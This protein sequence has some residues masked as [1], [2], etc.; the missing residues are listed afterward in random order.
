M[1]SALTCRQLPSVP[2]F[3]MRESLSNQHYMLYLRGTGIVDITIISRTIII[4][5][6]TITRAISIRYIRYSIRY[7]GNGILLPMSLRRLVQAQPLPVRG[8]YGNQV[9]TNT[10][11][12]DPLHD[13]S[14]CDTVSM[15]YMSLLIYPAPRMSTCT[16]LVN[17]L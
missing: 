9:C 11:A 7:P 17:D 4:I 12:F 13:M 6:T 1:S 10:L 5:I 14:W 15:F 16:V 8:V 3:R 2:H